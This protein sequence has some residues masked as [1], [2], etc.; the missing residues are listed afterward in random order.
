MTHESQYPL[1]TFVLFAYNQETYIREAVE[2]ALAQ[3]YPN[4]EIILSDDCSSDKTFD[5]MQEL[6]SG[7][8]GPHQ[9]VV[10]RNPEN[11]GL[12]RH[13]HEVVRIARG[14]FL[15]VAAGDDVSV[16]SRTSL[17]LDLMQREGAQLA[18][19]NF[20]R[21]SN[22]G[23]VLSKNESN[24]YSNNYLWKIID[25]D[26]KFFVN[27]ATAV[28]TRDFLLRAFSV[29]QVAIQDG[30]LYNEDI[31]LSAFAVAEESRPAS[32]IVEGLVNYRMNPDS[33]S[34]FER[35]SGGVIAQIELIRRE[36]FW[37]MTKIGILNVVH[38][39]ANAYPNFARCLNQE[40]ID[41]DQRLA[42]YELAA[43]HPRFS[44][45]LQNLGAASSA[46]QIRVAVA[47]LF[48]E[49]VHGVIRT[50]CSIFANGK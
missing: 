42:D 39:I 1:V 2:A 5:V 30:K 9:I 35:Q 34:N 33:L 14:S 27:G 18:A 26:S 28:Y 8:V 31:F 24:D 46:R 32:Y 11:L 23:C 38:E 22:S 12:G 19:S 17:M 20:N 48:G 15:V 45:R 25:T 41:R 37:A 50:M 4:L 16:P 49:K 36:R 47:R 43:S 44:R 29:A 13:F 40:V 21:M 10:R 7:Y 3:D 6:A